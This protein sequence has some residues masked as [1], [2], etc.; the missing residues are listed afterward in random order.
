MAGLGLGG[1][2]R[3]SSIA[4]PGI[5]VAGLVIMSVHAMKG[6]AVRVAVLIP[7]CAATMHLAY[8]TG[9]FWAIVSGRRAHSAKMHA[10]TRRRRPTTT[11]A[12]L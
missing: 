12:Q 4:L 8:A 11:T 2:W 6:K 5:Y 9:P 1:V 10:V 3:L 7:V